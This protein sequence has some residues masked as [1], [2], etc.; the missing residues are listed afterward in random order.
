MENSYRDEKGNNIGLNLTNYTL[1]GVVIHSRI[2][3]DVDD[4]YPNYHKELDKYFKQKDSEEYAWSFEAY[5]VACADEFAQWHH[6]LEDAIRGGALPIETICKVIKNSLEGYLSDVDFKM[7]ETILSNNEII[8]TNNK[9]DRKSLAELSHIV[10]NT[11]VNSL[12]KESKKN[13]ETIKNELLEARVEKSETVFK[14]Y[15]SLHLS[16][17]KES[18]I[19]LPRDIKSSEFEEIIRGSVHHSRAVERMNEKGKYIIRKLFEAYYAHPQQLPD[20]PILQ[21]LV[22]IEEYSTIDEAIK[23]G[24]GQARVR[25]DKIMKNPNIFIL[26]ILMRRICDHIASMTDRYAIDEYNNLYG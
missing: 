11:L 18:I 14:E 10:V 17:D 4:I 2:K 16:I 15:N 19:T 1:W 7:I 21:M 12:V 22:D 23:G 26:C 13:L 20:G 6:D 9:I 24:V 8:R 5:I 25:F 3:Y